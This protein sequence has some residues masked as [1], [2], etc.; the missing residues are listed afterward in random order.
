M[1]SVRSIAAEAA[2]AIVARLTGAAPAAGA[3][4]DAVD[5]VLKR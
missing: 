1:T 4:S 5:T 3:V 2:G